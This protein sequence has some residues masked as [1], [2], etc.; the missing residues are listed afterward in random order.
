M[1]DDFK[2]A[3]GLVEGTAIVFANTWKT[4]ATCPDITTRFVHPCSQG[5]NKGTASISLPMLYYIMFVMS[6]HVIVS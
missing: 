6:Y 3:S 5:I 1:T 4:R 2:V